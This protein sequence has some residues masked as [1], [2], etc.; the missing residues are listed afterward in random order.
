MTHLIQY[1]SPEGKEGQHEGSG[2]C[3][4]RERFPPLS[5]RNHLGQFLDCYSPFFSSSF[6]LR[7]VPKKE[8]K[9][10][11]NCL[12]FLLLYV[13]RLP[14]F[15]SLLFPFRF[16]SSLLT[17]L[18]WLFSF[19]LFLSYFPSCLVSYF[20]LGQDLVIWMEESCR[21]VF[22]HEASELEGQVYITFKVLKSLKNTKGNKRK[23]NWRVPRKEQK[24]KRDRKSREEKKRE[25]K[26]R[27]EK[28]DMEQR[29]YKERKGP[30]EPS[31][32]SNKER[33]YRKNLCFSVPCSSHLI[34]KNSWKAYRGSC[35]V[36]NGFFNW[37]WKSKWVDG[38]DWWTLQRDK[39]MSRKTKEKER[40]RR[41]E[42][43]RENS[44]T[45]K[46]KKKRKKGK[47]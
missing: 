2:C 41:N 6:V 35:Y 47:S 12:F 9:T 16:F 8:Q 45:G 21:L 38:L 32:L 17:Y 28:R 4:E 43:D 10:K 22:E 33:K 1:F 20:F 39:R 11:W 24:R 42:K 25:E 23:K 3:E 29:S 34:R 5:I 15:S 30:L 27:I 36:W 19:L 46:R 37:N 14:S 40:K 18:S 26:N 7:I 44:L 13:F 31:V